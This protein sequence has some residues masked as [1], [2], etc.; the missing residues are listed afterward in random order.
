MAFEILFYLFSTLT[1]LG[2]LS[3]ILSR[4]PVKAVISLIFTFVAAASVWMLLEVEF[5]ALVLIVVYVGAVMVLF[6]FVVMMIPVED[7]EHKSKFVSY[8]PIACVVGTVFLMLLLWS[9]TTGAF[10]LAYYPTPAELPANYSSI[11]MLG[12]TLYGHYLYAFMIAGM[13]L[14]SA[15]IAAI[16]L[17]FRGRRAGVKGLTP[18]QQIQADPKTRLKMVTMEMDAQRTGDS[19]V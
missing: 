2:A 13:I 10:G 8:W 6:M 5:L 17:T 9:I 3:V 14:F 18:E 15:M 4:N 12:I 19:H 1:V 11:H 7:A 16:A